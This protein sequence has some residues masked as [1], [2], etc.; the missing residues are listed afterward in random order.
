MDKSYYEK[1]TTSFF[2]SLIVFI[3]EGG[4]EKFNFHTATLIIDNYLYLLSVFLNAVEIGS[5]T[6]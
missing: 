2:N 4:G 3:G 1:V 5:I 6:T